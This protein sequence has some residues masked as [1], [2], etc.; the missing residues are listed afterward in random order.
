MRHERRT[1]EGILILIP[2]FIV[3]G[4]AQIK[5]ILWLGLILF[6][7]ASSIVINVIN[8]FASKYGLESEKGTILGTFRSLQ[9]LARAIGPLIASFAYWSI[10]EQ[11]TYVFGGLLL[12]CPVFILIN[13]H[14]RFKR[15]RLMPTIL[16]S[17]V[18]DD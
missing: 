18:K 11:T 16:V 8:S 15:M 10:G 4:F 6:S 5:L 7:I 17:E 2:S 14:Q 9:A 1:T 13:V 12:L 3:L